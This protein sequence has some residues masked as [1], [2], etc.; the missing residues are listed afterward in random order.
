MIVPPKRNEPIVT[1]QSPTQR[2]S[3]FME[4]LARVVNENETQSDANT[5]A[6]TALTDTADRRYLES[7]VTTDRTFDAD[8]V[9]VA[10]L[11]DIVGTLIK[12]LRAAGVIR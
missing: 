2:M 8:T 5:T 6:V 9:A 3:A 1:G 10:E 11:A 7:N 12:D 4:E